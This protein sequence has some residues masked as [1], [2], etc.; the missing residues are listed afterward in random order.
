MA[1]CVRHQHE[2]RNY[3]NAWFERA[4]GFLVAD[5]VLGSPAEK[6]RLRVGDKPTKVNSR[7]IALGDD[8]IVGIDSKIVRK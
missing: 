3:R 7:D 5:V 1:R 4:K 6:A 8:V 2:T